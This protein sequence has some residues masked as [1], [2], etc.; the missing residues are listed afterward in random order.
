[1]ETS[2]IIYTI[3]LFLGC[4][5]G[6]IMGIMLVRDTSL[7][8]RSNKWLA[9]ILF[10]FSYRLLAE[11]LKFFDIGFFD[12]AYH[13]T[14][15][16][17]WIY[18][19]LLYFFVSS[20][21]NPN[22]RLQ[23]KDFLHFIPVI[24][25]TL[26][27]F[28]IKTQNFF[29]DGTRESLSWAGYWGYVLWMHTPFMYV[30][31]G[32]ILLIYARKAQKLLSFGENKAW[33]ISI[34]ENLKW[35]RHLL[36]VHIIYAIVFT[37]IVIVDYL[38]FNYAFTH[39]DF[40]FPFIGLSAITYWMGIQGFAHRAKPAFKKKKLVSAQNQESLQLLATRIQE[41]MEQEFLYKNQDLSLQILAEQLEVKPYLITEC[42]NQVIGK[43][44]NRYV[45][46]FRLEEVKR[47][48]A[49]SAFEHYTLLGIAYEAGFNSKASF[50]RVVKQLTGL[51]PKE[52]KSSQ[53]SETSV[54]K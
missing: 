9:Y 48:L 7:Q 24:I 22:F 20:Y 43:K 17:N 25:E 23:R 35:V 31:A 10:F 46:E 29:W 16:Y 45:N 47:L 19:C 42:L 44:F 49:D 21:V 28:F 2:L 27:S 18:G 33:Y 11:A 30:V 51:S 5:Q 36:L 26:F 54:E 1:M 52:L 40:Y 12:L 34:P 53:L 3:L 6:L 14:L 15:E 41:A 13:L 38:F 8:Q 4:M 50:N 39:F 37:L 32:I